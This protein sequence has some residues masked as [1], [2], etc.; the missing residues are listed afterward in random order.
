SEI[1]IIILIR[2]YTKIPVPRIFRYKINSN[3]LT[4]VAF[5][6]IEFLLENITINTNS[7]YKANCSYIS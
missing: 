5:I 3:N 4:R 7:N 1:D 2:E 6:L